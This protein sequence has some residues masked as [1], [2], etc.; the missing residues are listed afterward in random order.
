MPKEKAHFNICSVPTEC[1]FCINVLEFNVQVRSMRFVVL[2]ICAQLC[3]VFW[4]FSDLKRE[5]SS[6]LQKWTSV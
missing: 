2:F 6:A 3:T 5:S 4:Q 1:D